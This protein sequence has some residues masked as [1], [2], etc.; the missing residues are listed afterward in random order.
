MSAPCMALRLTRLA[1]AA[2]STLAVLFLF[3]GFLAV[4]HHHTEGTP[5]SSSC[6][7]CHLAH[8]PVAAAPSAP[9]IKAPVRSE[10]TVTASSVSARTTEYDGLHS[11]RAPPQA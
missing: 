2:R 7:V 11:S 9:S 5:D 4:S 1:S 3:S 6:S 8:T 10:E